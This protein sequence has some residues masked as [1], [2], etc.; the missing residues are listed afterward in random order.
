MGFSQVL[1]QGCYDSGQLLPEYPF[2]S[3]PESRVIGRPAKDWHVFGL[4][5]TPPSRTD[6]V[7]GA[8]VG[9]GRAGL[10]SPQLCFSYELNNSVLGSLGV[11][12]C[13]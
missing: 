10:P 4:V 5:L 9:G 13:F 1:V 12:R 2:P 6:S 11:W 7:V 8:C 3:P